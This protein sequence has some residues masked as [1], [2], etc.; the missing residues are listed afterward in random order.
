MLKEIY[1]EVIIPKDSILYHTTDKD[2]NKNKKT[3]FLFCT[4]HPS[5]WYELNEYVLKIK[6][7]RDI[8]VLFMIKDFRK[9][10]INSSLNELLN[11]K[12]YLSKLKNEKKECFKDYLLKEDFDGWFSSIENRTNVEVALI[13]HNNSYEIVSVE[14]LK[15]NWRN[16]YYNNNNTYTNK[17][18][19]KL[20][21]IS[22]IE[23]PLIFNIN[24]RYEKKLNDYIKY[25]LEH[26]YKNDFVLQV[27][28]QNAII[29]YHQYK[30]QKIDWLC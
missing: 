5:D 2:Y 13:N 30:Y 6:L 14:N 27:I 20:Y 22:S 15:N 19:G 1:G 25:G 9:M 26:N 28:L 18:W 8:R 24:E 16:R 7:K 3:P 10:Q 29:H 17:N 12:D 23:K 11:N 4:F 21:K